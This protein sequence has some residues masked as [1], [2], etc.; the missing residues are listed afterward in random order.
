MTFGYTIIPRFLEDKTSLA[1]II[2]NGVSQN[3]NLNKRISK[4]LFTKK[5]LNPSRKKEAA[6]LK[7]K[8]TY[9]KKTSQAVLC[10]TENEKIRYNRSS[11]NAST[12]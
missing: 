4:L 3:S 12:N 7:F 8:K 9:L 11:L 5:E 2:R 6:G 10:R 1:G